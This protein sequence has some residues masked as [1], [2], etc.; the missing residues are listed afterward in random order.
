MQEVW[1]ITGP[2]FAPIFVNGQWLF[3]HPTIGHFPRLIQV[4]SH[5]F[6]VIVTAKSGEK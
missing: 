6:K 2:V 3:V 1:V 5:F 4:P